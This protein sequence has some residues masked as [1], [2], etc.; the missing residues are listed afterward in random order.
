MRSDAGFLCMNEVDIPIPMTP[1]M[2]MLI[3][4][5]ISDPLQ[6]RKMLLEGHRFNGVRLKNSE[7]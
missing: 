1:G 2:V 7:F 3:K 4:T 6:Y 5:K